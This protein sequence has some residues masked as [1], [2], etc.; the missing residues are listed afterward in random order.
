MHYPAQIS[1]S[2][3]FEPLTINQSIH[4]SA[5]ISPPES[6]G[7]VHPGFWISM[8]IAVSIYRWHIFPETHSRNWFNKIKRNYILKLK[9][10]GVLKEGSRSE[11]G[12][13]HWKFIRREQVSTQDW[14]RQC[15]KRSSSRYSIFALS[16][17]SRG[18][19]SIPTFITSM[20]YR[21][22]K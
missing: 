2:T 18:E 22:I 7:E 3:Q 21:F 10:W 19:A 11:L 5:P 4:L 12:Q 8:D 1:S 13:P 16:L 17:V 14:K 15:K 20:V 6:F 9:K